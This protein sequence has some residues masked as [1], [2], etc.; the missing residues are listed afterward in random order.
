LPRRWQESRDARTACCRHTSP[1]GFSC[2]NCCRLSSTYFQATTQPR[3]DGGRG[4]TDGFH[5]ETVQRCCKEFIVRG[6]MVYIITDPG[7]S[8]WRRQPD[9]RRR[10]RLLQSLNALRASS[11]GFR[12]RS[13]S[14]GSPLAKA[15]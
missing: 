6:F 9:S 11:S 12:R 14:A 3:Q 7:G 4:G 5:P 15:P 13:C 8:G 10:R 2:G 1:L